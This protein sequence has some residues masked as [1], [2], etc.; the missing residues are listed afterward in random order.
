MILKDAEKEF[1]GSSRLSFGID[2]DQI[3]RDL[4]FEAVRGTY[5]KNRFVT[6]LQQEIADIGEKADKLTGFL[7]KF[8]KPT[9]EID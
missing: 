6:G 3:T 1:D 9:C 8:C 7:G 4:D 5:N 2:G